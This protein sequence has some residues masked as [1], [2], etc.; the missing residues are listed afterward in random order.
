MSFVN[1]NC[2]HQDQSGFL[3]GCAQLTPYPY[4]FDLYKVRRI[5]KYPALFIF[6]V[7]IFALRV[8]GL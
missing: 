6:V 8:G 1:V 7:H 5:S 2:I 3:L 4:Y